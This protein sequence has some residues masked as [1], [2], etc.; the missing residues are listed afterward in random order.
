M[1]GGIAELRIGVITFS[2]PME[3]IARFWFGDYLLIWRP[4]SDDNRAL[5][6]GMAGTDV[7]W[8][9]ENLDKLNGYPTAMHD[10]DLFDQELQQLV[11]EFQRKN[12]LRIDG[13]AGSQTLITLASASSQPDTPTLIR[14]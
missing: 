1:D 14:E 4:V 5:S 11:R 12:R 10:S 8:L 6:L 9:R 7:R 13:I 2:V 3:A